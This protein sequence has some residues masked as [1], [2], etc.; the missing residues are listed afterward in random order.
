MIEP[1]AP[2]TCR[3]TG[4]APRGGE[5]D[6]GDDESGR[7][8]AVGDWRSGRGETS[9]RGTSVPSAEGISN[10]WQSAEAPRKQWDPS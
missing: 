5:D 6:S 2:Y 1:Y 10:L 8:G 3:S 4:G 9:V 7:G